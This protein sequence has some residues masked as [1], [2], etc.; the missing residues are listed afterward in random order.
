MKNYAKTLG[1][2]WDTTDFITT[3]LT[4]TFRSKMTPERK[5]HD[6]GFRTFRNYQETREWMSL[7]PGGKT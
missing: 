3:A 5:G 4:V 6:G 2:A 1:G 7:R